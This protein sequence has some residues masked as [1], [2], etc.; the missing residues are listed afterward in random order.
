MSA[1]RLLAALTIGLLATSLASSLVAF[2]LYQL[3]LEQFPQVSDLDD[4]I[5]VL[6]MDLFQGDDSTFDVDSIVTQLLGLN[7]TGELPN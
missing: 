3:G 1:D 2:H 4:D 6:G 7:S 5:G